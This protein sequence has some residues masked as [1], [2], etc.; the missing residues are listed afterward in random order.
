VNR[1]ASKTAADKLNQNQLEEN[2]MSRYFYAPCYIVFYSKNNWAF[3]ETMFSTRNHM[4]TIL[5][6]QANKKAKEIGADYWVVFKHWTT[7]E[8]QY[9]RQELEEMED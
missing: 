6:R 9:T 5:H 3:R 7:F 1:E 4:D 8:V 2:L